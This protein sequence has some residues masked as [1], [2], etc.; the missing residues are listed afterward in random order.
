MSSR[1]TL[2]PATPDDITLLQ[3][4]DE[5]P[6]VIAADPN[7]DWQWEA[8]LLKTYPWREQLIAMLD[9]IPIGFMEIIDPAEEES[10]YWGEIEANLR[11]L[12]IWIGPAKFLDK[13]YGTQM[14][15]LAIER[16]FSNPDVA[17][18]IIDPL[19][20]NTRA[21]RFYQRLGF[22][23]VENRRFDM[24]DCAVHRLTRQHWERAR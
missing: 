24:D 18:I 11:A 4:W 12:D 14:M 2:R 5:Q 10:H 6:H 9:E 17:A 16:C 19:Q 15:H 13:G 7:D 23:F 1:I 20:S 8:S 22:E 21:I 3:L